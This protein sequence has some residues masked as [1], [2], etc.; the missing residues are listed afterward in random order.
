MMMLKYLIYFLCIISFT[1]HAQ[2]NTEILRKEPKSDGLTHLINSQ[3]NLVQGNSDFMSY[4]VNYR[5]DLIRKKIKSFLVISLTESKTYNTQINQ[6]NFGHLRILYP[7]SQR[8][9]LETFIQEEFNPFLDLQN[10][11][12]YGL[13]YRY[14]L[15]TLF[16]MRQS[17]IFTGI[18]AML[19]NETH[20]NNT[21]KSIMRLSNYFT[22]NSQISES[23]SMRSISYFQPDI[24]NF[25]DFKI[26]SE[27]II[28][29][30][31]NKN[32][33]LNLHGNLKFDNKPPA[34]IK[35]YDLELIQSIEI[36]F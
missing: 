22:I 9:S 6:Y 7:L 35:K 5:A 27:N 21:K 19:E 33:S 15:N 28:S 26:L 29:S 36:L 17:D 3:V 18:G 34:E 2:I 31:L 10:R 16:Q 20:Q 8:S 1:S 11:Q 13:V 30:K 12:L 24:T 25:N 23:I 4:K 32:I 14:K